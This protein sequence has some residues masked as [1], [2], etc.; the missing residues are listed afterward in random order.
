MQRDASVSETTEIPGSGTEPPI[1]VIDEDELFE[2]AREHLAGFKLPRTVAYI[3]DLPRTVSG[4]VDREAVR[5]VLDD[6]GFPPGDPADR[7]SDAGFEPVD[8]KPAEGDVEIPDADAVAAT[9]AKSEGD[10]DDDPETGRKDASVH[11]GSDASA[12]DDRN[13]SAAEDGDGSAAEDGE[14]PAG[15]DGYESAAGGGN[16]PSDDVENSAGNEDE[17]ATIDRI[18]DSSETDPDGDQ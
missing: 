9:E 18:E 4:T 12:D 8:P 7:F 3:D 13:G 5:E 10:G 2:F 16:E 11:D 14:K 17:R 1:E 15:D 6:R